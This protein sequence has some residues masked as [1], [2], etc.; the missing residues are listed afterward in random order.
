M[1]D[2]LPCFILKIQ[3]DEIEKWLFSMRF[4][5]VSIKR[6]WTRG[7]RVL[8]VRKDL[9]VA[10]GTI[11]KVIALDE[12]EESERK[13]CIENNWYEKITF[14]KV[15]RF[16]PSL[17]ILGTPLEKQNPLVIHGSSISSNEASR[18]EAMASGKIIL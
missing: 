7:T 17:P 10:A 2:E 18:I 4:L 1:S 9:F 11:D 5:Y 12:L 16:I 3:K 6:Q 15:A 14:S 8:F 13:L